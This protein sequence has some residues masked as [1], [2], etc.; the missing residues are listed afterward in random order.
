MKQVLP[1][2]LLA[3]LLWGWDRSGRGN[4]FRIGLEKPVV[5]TQAVMSRMTR[6]VREWADWRQD[7]QSDAGRVAEL[8]QRVKLLALDRAAYDQLVTENRR[9]TALMGADVGSV[10]LTAG[11]G[12]GL[13]FGG[14]GEAMVDAGTTQG[15]RGGEVVIDADGVLV[16]RI[17]LSRPYVSVIERPIDTGAR[18]AVQISGTATQAVLT[19]RGGTAILEGVLQAETLTSGSVVVTSGSDGVYPPGLVVG[20]IKSVSQEAAAMTKQ[21]VVES[22]AS[23]EAVRIIIPADRSGE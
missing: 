14:A 15:L 5:A 16:G 20:V 12:A 11:L 10:N 3:L 2:L 22:L 6:P 7:S 21:A 18:L 1:W 23:G 17:R 19:G 13:L 8:E 9:L 4:W